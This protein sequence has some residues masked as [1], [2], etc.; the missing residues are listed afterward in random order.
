MHGASLVVSSE[1]VGTGC[2]FTVELPVVTTRDD[3][4][5]KI[6]NVGPEAVCF[7][8]ELNIPTVCFSYLQFLLRV[9]NRNFSAYHTCESAIQ[10]AAN[11]SHEEAVLV[12]EVIRN[13]NVRVAPEPTTRESRTAGTRRTGGEEGGRPG[14]DTTP[15]K[16]CDGDEICTGIQSSLQVRGCAFPEVNSSINT[17]I[18]S[19]SIRKSFIAV[20]QFDRCPSIQKRNE[21][22]T[23]RN[24]ILIVDDAPMNR[25]MMRRILESRF[26]I[27]DEA[28]NGQQAVD[29]IE[30]SLLPEE[31]AKYD[32]ITMDY[33]MPVMDGVTATRH[34]RNAGY[35]GLIVAVTGNALGEDINTFLSNGANAVLTKP[36]TISAF[37]QYLNS[38]E[39]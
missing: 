25:K 12:D 32:D 37:D 29:M 31:E 13:E 9:M 23:L 30:A 2:T 26:N 16:T 36:L 3:E 10:N 28:E 34:I 38:V 33:Q 17:L 22:I 8:E 39:S 15:V 20:T 14:S 1:G 19:S 27:V 7:S 5:K 24:R 4:R 18:K 6:A 35:T 21:L 11:C